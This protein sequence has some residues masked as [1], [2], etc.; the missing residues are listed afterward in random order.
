MLG[1]A[2]LRPAG[3]HGPLPRSHLANHGLGQ[4]FGSPGTT[5]QVCSLEENLGPVL[6][7]LQVPLLPG[8]HRRLYGP[9]DELLGEEQEVSEEATG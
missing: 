8:R 9:V 4:D 5:Q 1:H 7:R 2:Y 3:I 6:D